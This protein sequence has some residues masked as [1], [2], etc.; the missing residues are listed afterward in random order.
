MLEIIDILKKRILRFEILVLIFVC[1][2][3]F[4]LVIYVF[5]YDFIQSV[6]KFDKFYQETQD[7]L[8]MKSTQNNS[9]NNLYNKNLKINYFD[10]SSGDA[11]FFDKTFSEKVENFYANLFLL[12]WEF[13]KSK[14]FLNWNKRDYYFNFWNLNLLKWY[15]ILSGN[16]N[17]DKFLE[18]YNLIKDSIEKYSIAA[19]IVGTW[20]KESIKNKIK[21]N[22]DTANYFKY[23]AWEKFCV[24]FFDW[25]IEKINS[26]FDKI[27]NLADLFQKE[28]RYIKTWWEKIQDQELKKCLNNFYNSV[29]ESYI[30]SLSLKERIKWYKD[31]AVNKLELWIKNPS[32]C[33]LDSKDFQKEFDSISSSI[34][35]I[36]NSYNN[37]HT[38]LLEVL[39]NKDKEKLREVCKNSKQYQKNNNKTQKKLS[40]S[41]KKMEDFLGKNKK[42]NK[43]WQKQEKK[44]EKKQWNSNEK[45][46]RDI[47]E[48]LEEELRKSIDKQN[49]KWIEEMNKLKGEKGFTPEKYI[50][51]LFDEFY[52][53]KEWF[54]TNTWKEW[55]KEKDR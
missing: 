41:L 46:H 28:R 35:N 30:Q 23:I 55:E 22:K 3:S 17:T 40:E 18:S 29:S 12:N 25:L 1:I 2:F 16:K 24:T 11:K 14:N 39:K 38:Y 52:G 4:L 53:D 51:Q 49:Q 21:Q 13:E 48:G 45:R 43:S 54:E 8:D 32:K 34:T 33:V 27:S 6:E 37:L 44:S 42:Q 5:N 9:L 20:A 50:E 15:S 36:F 19:Q 7:T 47:P 26:L 10:F 31:S